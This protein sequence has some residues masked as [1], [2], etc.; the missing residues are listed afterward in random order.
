MGIMGIIN[1]EGS[2]GVGEDVVGLIVVDRGL[3]VGR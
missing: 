3:G 1:E 2:R